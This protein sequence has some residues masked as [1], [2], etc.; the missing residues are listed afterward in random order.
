MEGAGFQR[1]IDAFLACAA[2]AARAVRPGHL[3]HEALT[4]G[5]VGKL[6]CRKRQWLHDSKVAHYSDREVPPNRL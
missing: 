4:G 3:N 5:L 1:I 6:F 2:M